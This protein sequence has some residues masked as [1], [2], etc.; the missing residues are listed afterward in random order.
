MHAVGANFALLLRQRRTNY[1]SLKRSMD[2]PIDCPVSGSPAGSDS[3]KRRFRR[4][5]NPPWSGAIILE[6]RFS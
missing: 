6:P 3:P 2:P 4:P 1:V 5:A